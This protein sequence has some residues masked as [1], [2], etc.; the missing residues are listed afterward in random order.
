[1]HVPKANGTYASEA[2]QRARLARRAACDWQ[3]S[4]TDV[5]VATTGARDMGKGAQHLLWR[6]SCVVRDCD[7]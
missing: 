6:G 4:N 3:E 2:K 7:E 5:G 1:M